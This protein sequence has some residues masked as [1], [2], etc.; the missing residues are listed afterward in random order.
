[1][2]LMH[3]VTVLLLCISSVITFTSSESTNITISP[4]LPCPAEVTEQC[5]TLEQFANNI[6]LYDHGRNTSLTLQLLPGNHSL[7]LHMIFWN[8]SFLNIS[9]TSHDNVNINCKG[10]RV[11]VIFLNVSEVLLTH[12]TFYHCGYARK[13]TW[14]SYVSM[15]V[16]NVTHSSLCITKCGFRKSKGIVIRSRRSNINDTGSVYSENVFR[17]IFS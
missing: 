6:S 9:S 10:E 5:L 7:H 16:L 15:P 11:G 14:H 13:L 2:L 3:R 1:M 17:S 4:E 8:T 12:L